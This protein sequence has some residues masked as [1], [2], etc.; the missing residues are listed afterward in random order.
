MFKLYLQRIVARLPY[1]FQTELKRIHYAR[2]IRNGT[3][4]T[5]EPEY[6]VLHQ[7]I[8]PGD[9]VLDIGANVGHYTKRFSELVGQRGRVIAFEPVP[10]TFYLLTANVQLFP[11][12][13]V[14]LL[15]TAVSDK[16]DIVAMSIPDSNTGAKDYYRSHID[17]TS[18]SELSVLTLSLDQ[19]FG[20]QRVSLIKID[21]EGHEPFIMTGM[22]KLIENHR[23]VL[24][25]ETKSDE[26]IDKLTNNG[27]DTLK[28][29]NSPN[30][31]FK[32]TD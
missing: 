1:K 12:S 14:T 24:I 19:I 13:N 10:T 11:Y 30:I 20:S 32:S 26:I 16:L 5:N 4:L 29:E 21:A 15:N 6:K 17:E 22:Q 3:F 25:I 23:P 7:F 8:S 31:I 9:L 2:Q 28:F 18:E 27:Y